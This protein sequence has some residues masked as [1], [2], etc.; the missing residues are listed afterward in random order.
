MKVI[1]MDFGNYNVYMSC[2][3]DMD[4]E[5][6][7]GGRPYDLQSVQGQEG[8]PSTYLLTPS[9]AVKT[10]MAT[11]NK[12]FDSRAINLLK[13]RMGSRETIRLSGGQ[14]TTVEIDQAITAV[15]ADCLR[16]A[17]ETLSKDF[18]PPEKT[19]LVAL[20]HPARFDPREVERLIE[21]VEA[22]TLPDGTHAKV[23]GTI[24]EPAA[25]ALDYLSEDV[26]FGRQDKVT[27]LTMDLGA[28]T[29]DVALVTAYP[30]GTRD[31]AGNVRY[32]NCIDSD[33]IEGL[34]GNEF[35]FALF[36][37]ATK[38]AGMTRVADQARSGYL[39]DTERAKK[40]LSDSPQTSIVFFDYSSGDEAELTVTREEFERCTRSLMDKI[41]EK[42]R[43]LVNRN[44]CTHVDVVVVTG[45]GGNMPMIQRAAQ[46][47]CPG[48]P[49]RSYRPSKAISYGAARYYSEA[50]GEAVIRHTPTDIGIWFYVGDSDV[51]RV[52]V[53]IP[54]GSELPFDQRAVLKSETRSESQD[55][56]RFRVAKARI[57]DPDPLNAD[58]WDDVGKLVY[59]FSES[60]PK[61][62]EMCTLL[63]I[64]QLGRLHI[65]CWAPDRPQDGRQKG[66][67]S[68]E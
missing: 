21:L 59:R 44:P 48:V 3:L 15:A 26:Q 7:R 38:R 45:G 19:N 37:H 22:A 55:S 5:T 27:A 56:C 34:G 47:I 1:G 52:S 64:D 63:S 11:V 40:D 62:T 68:W 17:N 65:E 14:Q 8:I 18:S 9:G 32:Y 4:P 66:S 36:D 61:D 42:T 31:A 6:R 24:A 25:A 53:C 51:L 35:T 16:I 39:S 2:I 30:N 33:G 12:R 49:V 67:F 20:A 29:Y 58:D 60:V 46:E 43:A 50:F 57:S 28:G 54:A 10:G 41:V 13:R 23:V